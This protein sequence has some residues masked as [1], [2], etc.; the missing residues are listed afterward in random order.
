MPMVIPTSP[1]QPRTNL[2]AGFTLQAIFAGALAT[3]I[4]PLQ[5]LYI[6]GMSLL[7]IRLTAA[8]LGATILQHHTERLVGASAAVTGTAS[9][10]EGNFPYVLFLLCLGLALYAT[11]HY[12]CALFDLRTLCALERRGKTNF[13]LPNLTE[14]RQWRARSPLARLFARLAPPP[15]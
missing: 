5:L 9:W 11:Y 15:H 1:S 4:P 2:L 10:D 8:A 13:V 3:A 12:R 6:L 14:I 7:L